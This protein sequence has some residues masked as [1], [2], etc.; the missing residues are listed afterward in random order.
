MRRDTALPK[1]RD[2]NPRG[3]HIPEKLI[4]LTRQL[5]ILLKQLLNLNL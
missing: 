4:N 1:R 3:A 2:G 5:R